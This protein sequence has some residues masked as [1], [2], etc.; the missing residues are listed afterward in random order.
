M[1]D[2][3]D[4]VTRELEATKPAGTVATEDLEQDMVATTAADGAQT[5]GSIK[6]PE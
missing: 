4:L 1:E 3:E 6:L 2:L 5:M